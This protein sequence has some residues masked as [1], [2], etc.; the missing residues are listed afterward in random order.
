[1]ITA[2]KTDTLTLRQELANLPGLASLGFAAA[3]RKLIYNGY[4]Q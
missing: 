4:Y 1:M 2:E 3:K